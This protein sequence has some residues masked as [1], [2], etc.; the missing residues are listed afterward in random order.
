M[1]TE[2]EIER[3]MVRLMGDGSSY[4]KMLEE[5]ERATR[6]AADKIQTEA[7]KIN[8]ADRITAQTKGLGG[9]LMTGLNAVKNFGTLM[10]GEFNSAGEGMRKMGE[11]AELIPGPWGKAVGSIL[12]VGGSL[13]DFFNAK[14]IKHQ[15][16]VK[17]EFMAMA[18]GA[19]TFEAALA[20]L[21]M[22]A[23][24]EGF[25]KLIKDMQNAQQLQGIF[26]GVR[27]FI[28]EQVEST[29]R[30]FMTAEQG[31]Q[32]TIA[33]AFA[34]FEKRK[35]LL[36]VMR[37]DTATGRS[38]RQMSMAI[39]EESATSQM[40][41]M[42]ESLEQRT[43]RRAMMTAMH[44]GEP[45]GGMS[46]DEAIRQIMTRPIVRAGQGRVT[47]QQAFE[48]IRGEV[49]AA[50]A[51]VRITGAEAAMEKLADSIQNANKAGAIQIQT[52]R[53]FS[54]T[55]EGTLGPLGEATTTN[56]SLARQDRIS[57][58]LIEQ[59]RIQTL[60]LAAAE[61]SLN[62]EQS[63]RLQMSERLITTRIQE[64]REQDR[65]LTQ[66]E[67]QRNADKEGAHLMK[68]LRTPLEKYNDE[69]NKLENLLR[70]G[71]ISWE[72]YARG[73]E[74]AASA[75]N[76]AAK[77]GMI[78]A[79]AMGSLEALVGIRQQWLT[80]P[81]GSMSGRT[82]PMGVGGMAP[83]GGGVISGL[84]VLRAGSTI[85][86]ANLPLSAQPAGGTGPMP[87]GVAGT[88][89]AAGGA[90]PT[91]LLTRIADAVEESLRISQRAAGGFGGS[92]VIRIATS[93]IAGAL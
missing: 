40:R 36:E 91:A 27:G 76:S 25:E 53:A 62:Q 69:L 15:Q 8:F 18:G 32:L 77:S 90:V 1:A 63:R 66:M 82:P 17:N 80:Q 46:A 89:A 44:G 38:M 72:F 55:V 21:K 42:L 16:A 58:D 39:A 45:H 22:G 84:D 81:A 30:L 73:V 41:E 33:K 71:S 31:Q 85:P 60:L 92:A 26:S 68:E 52:F 75:M 4:M 61:S 70:R 88:A 12:N 83:A 28:V 6:D 74:R 35:Q 9:T 48:S 2:S 67:L 51:R 87:G 47:E 49:E 79:E 37:S 86:G 29:A 24:T 65:I 13:V 50:Q 56:E 14:L 43:A 59:R 19:K 23:L 78:A 20:S 5:G 10:K 3:M 54:Q 64:A 34:A 93:G 57:K 7:N 11:V